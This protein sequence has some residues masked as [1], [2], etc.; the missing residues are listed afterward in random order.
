[1]LAIRKC[2]DGTLHEGKLEL[3]TLDAPTNPYERGSEAMGV[4][5]C[6]GAVIVEEA[7]E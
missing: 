1:M 2:E 4:R 3:V 5:G 6:G 7:V